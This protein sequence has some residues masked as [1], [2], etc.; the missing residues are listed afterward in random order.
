MKKKKDAK[1]AEKGK[2]AWLSHIYSDY[3]LSSNFEIIYNSDTSTDISQ[4]L[5][6]NHVSEPRER[7]TC[8]VTK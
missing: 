6:L 1:K 4:M 7:D 5:S 3:W 8:A 2:H